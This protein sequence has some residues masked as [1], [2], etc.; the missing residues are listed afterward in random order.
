MEMTGEMG[1]EVAPLRGVRPDALDVQDALDVRDPRPPLDVLG[2]REVFREQPG[3][4]DFAVT[5]ADARIRAT[6]R[7]ITLHMASVKDGRTGAVCVVM[8][9]IGRERRYLLARHWRVSTGAWEWEFPRGMGEPEETAVR[10][11]IRELREETG[12]NVHDSQVSILQ[13][14]HA[15]TGVLRDS[16]AVARIMVGDDDIA[17]VAGGEGT[18]CELDNCRWLT[19]AQMR[20][21]IAA[22][23]IVDG[24]TLAAFAIV[25]CAMQDEVPSGPSSSDPV[26]SDFVE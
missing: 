8:H 6:G 5:A 20:G 12:I 19:A 15:D 17:G 23:G 7:P 16:I 26:S 25:E 1:D 4:A 18:D 3:G 24:I 11:A 9:G 2:E 14:M 21:L 22:G 10:T 13:T